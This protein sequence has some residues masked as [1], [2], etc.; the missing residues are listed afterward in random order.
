VGVVLVTHDLA[1]IVP[2]IDRVV[3]LQGGRVV[4]DG[5]KATVL[6]QAALSALFG[7]AVEL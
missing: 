3:L 4:A 6:T 7:V 5:P 2:E 1:E